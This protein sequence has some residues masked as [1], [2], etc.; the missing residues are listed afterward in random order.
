MKVNH[1]NRSS[2]PGLSPRFKN[3]SVLES[4]QGTT[5]TGLYESSPK[6]V[7]DQLISFMQQLI[8]IV[9]LKQIT[10]IKANSALEQSPAETNMRSFSAIMKDLAEAVQALSSVKTDK[11][12][13]DTFQSSKIIMPTNN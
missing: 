7:S 1:Y 12:A 2:L 9:K 11:T 5:I 13:V 8:D 3:S 4:D 6:K 10:Q